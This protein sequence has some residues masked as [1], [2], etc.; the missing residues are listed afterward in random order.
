MDYWR[1]RGAEVDFVV[2]RRGMVTAIEVKSGQRWARRSGLDA[3]AAAHRTD[4]RLLV[5]GDGIP[6]EEF[7]AQPVTD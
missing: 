1:H 2:L 3:F 7:L 4:R 6:V 5:G